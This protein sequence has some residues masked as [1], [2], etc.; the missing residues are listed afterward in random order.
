MNIEI[1]ETE[2]V[3]I[4][5]WSEVSKNLIWHDIHEIVINIEDGSISYNIFDMK[6]EVIFRLDN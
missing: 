1:I 2:K 5:T 3:K 4:L 6:G